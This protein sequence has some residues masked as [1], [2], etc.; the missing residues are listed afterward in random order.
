[1]ELTAMEMAQCLVGS[2]VGVAI[3]LIVLTAINVFIMGTRCRRTDYAR[4]SHS[5]RAPENYSSAR[6]DMQA[7]VKHS[8]A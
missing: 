7:Q 6:A 3:G 8:K 1:M 2:I 5:A 4:L